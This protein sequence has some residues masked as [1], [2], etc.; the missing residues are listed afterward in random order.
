MRRIDA[1]VSGGGL[2]TNGSSEITALGRWAG[3]VD[4]LASGRPLRP[5]QRAALCAE[6]VLDSRRHLVVCAPTNSG[7]SMIGQLILLDAVRMGSRAILLEPLRALARE[8]GES[9]QQLVAELRDPLLPSPPEVRISTG[10]YRLDGEQFAGP[11]PAGGEIIVATP[12]RLEAILR[13]PSYADWVSSIGAVVVDEAHLLGDRL[14]GPTLELLIATLLSQSAPPRIVLLSATLGEPERLRDWLSPCQIVTSKERT[15]LKKE[16]WAVDATE[17]VDS[18]LA[19]EI[20]SLLID[21]SQAVLVFV[22]R[23]ASTR[24][25]ASKIEEISGIPALP[26][27]SGQSS[28]ERAR[29]R[30][31]FGSGS[32]RCLVS[33]TALAMGVNLP[34]TQ[35]IVRDTTFFG[36]GKLQA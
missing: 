6:R 18:I 35:V 14:R 19:A 1:G 9:L 11:P 21:P 34:A 36:A 15:V 13:N 26:Y 12:E 32:C 5:V 2:P 22:Y 27:H 29:I 20:A 24:A 10:D 28:S 25:L 4:H 33:T 7:K 30:G 8:Q 3:V 17:D 31:A 23:R 16:I